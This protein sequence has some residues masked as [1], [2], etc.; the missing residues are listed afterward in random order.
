M[1]AAGPPRWEHVHR[2]LQRA[3]AARRLVP[4]ALGSAAVGFAFV[5]YASRSLRGGLPLL[6]AGL[7]FALLVWALSSPRC[8]ACGR[9]LWVRGERP[10]PATAPR[11]TRVERERRCPRCGTAFDG[12]GAPPPARR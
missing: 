3:R 7:L 1:P 11:A 10:G 9:G 2:E 12:A 8:P 6:G 5:A 4:W